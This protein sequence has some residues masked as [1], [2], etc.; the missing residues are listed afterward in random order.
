MLLRVCLG[1]IR[2]YP[3][4]LTPTAIFD[5]K[6]PDSTKEVACRCNL[7]TLS[8]KW[9][10]VRVRLPP[11]LFPREFLTVGAHDALTVFCFLTLKI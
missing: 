7:N 9:M 11:E 3:A 10:L 8:F 4:E 5:K 6:E 1:V 2:M